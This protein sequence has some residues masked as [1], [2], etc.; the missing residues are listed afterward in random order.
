MPYPASVAVLGFGFLGRPL[1]EKLYE[2]GVAVKAVKRR[3]TSDDINLPLE[4]SVADLNAPEAQA[5]LFADWADAEAWVCLLPPS[6]VADYAGLMQ[7]LADAA[8]QY[9]V[10]HLV[11]GSSI[12]VYGPEARECDE[13]SPIRPES[14]S[15]EQTA[16]AERILSASRVPHIDILRLGGLYSGERHP[17]NSLLRRGTPVNGN[18]AACM[19]HQ[20][21]A[22]SALMLALKQPA[23]RRI[24]NLVE[25]PLPDKRRF[26]TAEA[27]K[28]GLNPPEFTDSGSSGRRVITRY[29]DFSAI[30]H[31]D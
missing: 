22:V 31:T 16:A 29:G 2:Q 10:S 27:A 24:R 21:R 17:L 25:T 4:L 8:E 23:G 9:G 7:R 18:E 28:L 11:D 5:A 14:A 19:L 3:L 1:A 26:Y 12:G 20:N 15:A 30:L 13:D 6:G